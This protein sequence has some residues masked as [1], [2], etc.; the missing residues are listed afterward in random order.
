M[1]R[2]CVPLIAVLFIVLPG[3]HYAL[4]HCEILCGIYDDQM[5]I[6]MMAE[7]IT[8][9]PSIIVAAAVSV[10]CKA[11]SPSS[12]F[13]ARVGPLITGTQISFLSPSARRHAS[14]G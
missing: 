10:S 11:L 12:G 7:H 9:L 14:K 4:F 8:T 5:R 6:Q 13:T 1:Q 2:R 3:A